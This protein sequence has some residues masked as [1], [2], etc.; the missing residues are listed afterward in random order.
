VFHAM[1][2]TDRL[3]G[4][5]RDGRS[6]QP[7]REELRQ[8][9]A[10][11]FEERYYQQDWKFFQ[12][13]PSYMSDDHASY[14]GWILAENPSSGP[15]QGTSF[16]WFPGHGDS[17]AVLVIG[18]AGFGPDAHMLS[19][20]GHR[21]RLQALA[22]LH[23]MRNSRRVRVAPAGDPGSSTFAIP[24][25]S[26]FGTPSLVVNILLGLISRCTTRF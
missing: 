17:V 5:L 26:N 9:L 11:L 16:V 19:R 25:S 13:R 4:G 12:A 18:T 7:P 3:L 1:P 2:A 21:R 20:P 22:R 8:F 24:K 10:E 23:G 15:Y 6:W 14:A